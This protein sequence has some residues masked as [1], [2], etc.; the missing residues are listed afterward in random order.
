MTEPFLDP[1][2][3]RALA[4]VGTAFFM[5]ILDVTVVNLAL[6]S[7]GRDLGFEREALQWVITAYAIPFGGFLL[8]A[9]R[10]ADLLG[11]RS[12]FA[13]GVALFTTASLVCGLSES[14][15]LLIAARAVQGLGA[16]IIA[17]TALAIVGVAFPEGKER[18]Q[19]LG[20]WGAIGGGGAAI[21]VLLGG[22]VTKYLGW[23][24][25]FLLN[26]PLGVLVLAVTFAWVRESR[27]AGARRNFDLLG[28]LAVTGSLVLLVY[29]IADAPDVGWATARTILLLLGSA[30][31]L[32]A[33]VVIEQRAQSPLVPF[34]IFGL[35]NVA[36]ANVIGVIL[37]V[38]MVST[39]FLLSLYVQQVLRYSALQAGAAFLACAGTAVVAAG[40]AEPVIR[41][42]GA[43]LMMA[44]GLVLMTAGLLWFTQI[45]A[46]GSY[47]ADLMPGLFLAGVGIAFS[48]VPVSIAALG[49]VDERDEGL[50]S[51]LINTSQQ[52]G[53]GVGVAVASSVF[54][55][56]VTTLLEEGKPPAEALTNAF[57]LD[58]W[59]IAA[60]TAA[61]LIAVVTL[62]RRV[63]VPHPEDASAAPAA[64]SAFVPNRAATAALTTSLLRGR[65]GE[66]PTVPTDS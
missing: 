10:A 18:N 55:S 32:A 33:F 52:I 46:D 14:A 60:V 61:G 35:P 5:T 7:L 26:V 53:T 3:W 63:E 16:A 62:L 19:A 34:R 17:P 11:R 43:K 31:L 44:L 27:A 50:A 66:L 6:P 22:I 65:S 37:G 42:L 1:H 30:V 41:R 15:S 25:I 64:T 47:V 2:R 28:A 56:R 51:G 4:V 49:G 39:F 9:G 12:V 29:A 13:A 57:R 59:V 20:V 38:G 24:W 23:E 36:G 8:L 45:D 58:F 21:G 48:F 54:A 40:F